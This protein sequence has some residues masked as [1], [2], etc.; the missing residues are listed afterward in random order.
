MSER[1]VI[2]KKLNSEEGFLKQVE[3][4]TRRQPSGH[5]TPECVDDAFI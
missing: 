5:K 3:S 1:T 4:Y 2:K